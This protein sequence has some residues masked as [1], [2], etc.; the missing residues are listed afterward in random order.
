MLSNKF[1]AQGKLHTMN[2]KNK[3]ISDPIIISHRKTEETETEIMISQEETKF[4]EGIE[5]SMR[6]GMKEIFINTIGMIERMIE[7]MIG[8]IIGKGMIRIIR[9]IGIIG[10]IGTIGTTEI[11][12]GEMIIVIKIKYKIEMT[13]RIEL[14]EIIKILIASRTDAELIK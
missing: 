3:S 5:M 1:K 12:R 13:G 4:K 10:T 7:G 8:E 6:E 2:A 14:I 11:I 9:I